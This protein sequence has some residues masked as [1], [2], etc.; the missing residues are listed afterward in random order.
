MGR[1][2]G[3][4]HRLVPCRGEA[5]RSREAR[6]LGFRARREGPGESP[7]DRRASE[8]EPRPWSSTFRGAGPWG[9]QPGPTPAGAVRRDEAARRSE[10]RPWALA[11]R[12]GHHHRLALRRTG[13]GA[14]VRTRDLAQAA[15]KPKAGCP[16]MRCSRPVSAVGGLRQL[17]RPK[18]GLGRVW[19]RSAGAE[20]RTGP[21]Q[22]G[23]RRLGEACGRRGARRRHGYSRNHR[24]AVPR[25]L[26]SLERADRRLLPSG[27]MAKYSVAPVR[28]ERTRGSISERVEKPLL[29]RQNPLGTRRRRGLE[30]PDRTPRRAWGP[31]PPPDRRVRPPPRVT[32]RARAQP[33]AARKSGPRL[34]SPAPTGP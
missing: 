20:P 3:A 14:V 32:A 33:D 26:L 6:R 31:P 11:V 4:L 18:P 13:A 23:D 19:L 22:A 12:V 21:R 28:S 5:G 27:L 30:R 7:V 29:G 34:P 24:W 9:L 16:P 10:R 2:S 25:G 8:Q 1:W 17:C 15:A